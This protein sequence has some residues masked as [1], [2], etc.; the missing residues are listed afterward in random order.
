MKIGEQR[1]LYNQSC[2]YTFGQRITRVTAATL[3]NKLPPLLKELSSVNSF[4]QGLKV[5]LTNHV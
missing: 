2:R 1:K 5:H 3:W 4:K